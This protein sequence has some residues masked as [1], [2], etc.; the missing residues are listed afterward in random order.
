MKQFISTLYILAIAVTSC[1][2]LSGCEP[3]RDDDYSISPSPN[4]ASFSAHVLES[5]SNRVVITNLTD[6]GFQH[7]W[8]LPGGL[9]KTS[10]KSVDT[11]FY[12]DAGTYTITLF[13]SKSDGTGT[14]SAS[15]QINI[16]RD[17]PLECSDKLALL[18]GGCKVDGKCWTFSNA[19]GAVKVGP[20][21]GDYSWYVSP[22]GGLQ[23]AQ[24]DDRYCFYFDDFVFIN[25]NNGQSVN[26]WNG[27][28]AE[29]YNPGISEFQFLEGTGTGGVDQ[30]IIPDEQFM[31]V[32]DADNVMDVISLT[33][34]ELVVRMRICAQN[35]EPAAEGWFEL[36]FLAL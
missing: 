21:Y 29:D 11:I 23:A 15:Q 30:L 2:Y 28:Q 14:V 22:E 8:N 1:I 3:Q 36:T 24:Y 25:D 5:D 9:P 18:T 27:Y 7:L 35:G 33:E 34:N 20:N 16:L 6:G 32:W 17:A 12:S 13:V 26:P 19:G 4:T 31:G 10:V